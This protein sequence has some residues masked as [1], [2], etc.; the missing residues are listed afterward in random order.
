MWN[1]TK[2]RNIDFA[3][4]MISGWLLDDAAKWIG[5]NLNPGDVFEKDDLEEWAE[6]NGYVKEG[7][8]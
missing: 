6:E 2:A 8:P 5:K 3:E 7:K 4:D 1:F